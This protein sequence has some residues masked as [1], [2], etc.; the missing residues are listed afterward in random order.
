MAA[1][2]SIVGGSTASRVINCPGSVAL[3][4]KMPPQPSSKYADE[5]TLLHEVIAEV[6]GTSKNPYDFIGRKV[7][8]IE[9]TR[10]LIDEKLVPAMELFGE[11]DPDYEMEF[12]VETRVGFGDLLPDVFG[13]TDVI[14]RKGDTAY[15]I[16][17]KFG[18]GVPVPAEENMQLMF[19]ACAAMRTE[20]TKW[21]FDGAKEIEMVIIQPPSIK[22]WTTTFERL[23]QFEADLVRAVKVAGSPDAPLKTGS[24]CR[25]CAAKPVCPQMTGAVDRA[26]KTALDNLPASQIGECLAQAEILE[27]WIRSLRELA[28]EMME[29]DKPVPGWKLVPKRAIRQWTDAKQAEKFL[30]D[31]KINPFKEPELLTPAGAE[32]LLKKSKV[33]LPDDLV[34]AVSSGSTLAPADDPRPAV[35]NVGKQ[36]TAAL[37][38]LQ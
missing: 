25:W 24:H 38:K 36:L 19:Y 32:K 14:G 31:N 21:A 15:V 13:S 22:R 8:D 5:G 17:Y 20:E 12:E 6:M 29:N 2:S 35:L 27:D 11:I 26:V 10:D 30:K 16:D 23:A 4:A 1:H 28:H 7:G 37:S 9:L 3:V 33:A 34:V 18:D